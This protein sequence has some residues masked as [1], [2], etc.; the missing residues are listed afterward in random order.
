MK[1]QGSSSLMYPKKNFTVKFDDAFEACEA[2]SRYQESYDKRWGKQ[3]KYNLKANWIDAS[4]LRNIVSARLWSDIV[5]SRSGLPETII[6]SPMYGAVDGFPVIVRI[7]GVVHGLYTFNIPKDGWMFGMGN[8][9]KEAIVCA[10]IT[11]SLGTTFKGS[12]NLNG[13]FELEYATDENNTA[14]V[15]DSLKTMID[16][17][18]NSDGSDLDSNLARYIDLNSAIDYFIYAV[19]LRG[20]DMLS[21]NYLLST[22]DGT[23]WRFGAYDL[24]TTF[25]IDW[26]GRC[27]NTLGNSLTTFNGYA[28][29]NRL[30]G[31]LWQY[32]RDEIITRYN[33]IRNNAMSKAA[34]YDRFLNFAAMIPQT[35]YTLDRLIWPTVPSSAVTSIEQVLIQYALSCEVADKELD[36]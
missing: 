12:D 8:G 16:A 13:D 32:K 11:G 25:G 31:L 7:N 4:H 3:K 9:E 17:C 5:A 27:F 34:V 36:V 35:A 14:W 10:E 30:M 33:D 20:T 18:I 2:D 28:G 15:W 22:Y 1:W 23:K 19:L 6:N 29:L 26:N 24:D 21:R